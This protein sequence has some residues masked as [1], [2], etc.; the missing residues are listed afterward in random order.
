MEYK[1]KSEIKNGKYYYSQQQNCNNIKRIQKLI[2]SHRMIK[3]SIRL[4]NYKPI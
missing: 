2:T 1:I 3:S 4:V